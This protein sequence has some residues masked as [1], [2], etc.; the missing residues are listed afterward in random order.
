VRGFCIF[1]P[2]QRNYIRWHIRPTAPQR[3]NPTQAQAGRLDQRR[4]HSPLA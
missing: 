3:A 1:R 2:S 4:F